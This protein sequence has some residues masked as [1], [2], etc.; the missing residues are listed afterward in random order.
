MNG[1]PQVGLLAVD[2]TL[3]AR[4]R[5][6]RR[7]RGWPRPKVG[8]AVGGESLAVI[9]PQNG[10]VGHPSWTNANIGPGQAGALDGMDT[11]AAMARK[12]T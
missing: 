8:W 7:A 5:G 12:R 11:S 1:L 3:T 4:S 10:G 6:I 9:T 2:F